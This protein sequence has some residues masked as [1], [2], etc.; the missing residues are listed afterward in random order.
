ML[1]L[2][3]LVDG[4]GKGAIYAALALAIVVAH[5]STGLINFAQGEFATLSAMLTVALTGLGLGV[6]PALA[7]AAAASFAAGALIQV[8]IVRPAMR[9]DLVPVVIMIGLYVCANAIGQLTFGQN[10]RPLEGL[11]PAGGLVFGGIRVQWSLIGVI[12]LQAV[13]ITALTL[14]FVRTKI[15]LGFRAVATAPEASRVAGIPVERM[16]MIG[17]GIAAALGAV[18]GVSLTNLGV[19]VESH[20]MTTV[21]VYSLAAVTIGGFDSAL[22]AIVGGAIMGVVE[23]LVTGLVPGVSGDVG[24]LVS[25]TIIVLILLSR[26]Q[27]LFGR[28][29]VARV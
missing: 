12:L 23:S 27:G 7:V 20:M 26:P 16:H 21:L 5:R 4:V 18:A 14:F 9:R 1:A 11:F 28:E 3:L 24:I 6:W 15:G 8:V 29:R 25:L 19:Y 2:Q 10:P 13:V 17:W 22:G